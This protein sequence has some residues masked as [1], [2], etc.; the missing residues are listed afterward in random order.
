MKVRAHPETRP[1]SSAVR[2]V[3]YRLSD[4]IDVDFYR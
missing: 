2:R 4:E 1:I 3:R